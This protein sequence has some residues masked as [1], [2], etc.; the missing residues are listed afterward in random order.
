MSNR[1][2]NPTLLGNLKTK[3]WNLS[4]PGFWGTAIFLSVV[5]L[6]VKEYLTHPDFLSTGQKEQVASQKSTDSSLSVEDRA[7]AADI[8]NLP[9][10]FYNIED[11]EITSTASTPKKNTR[12]NDNKGVVNDLINANSNPGLKLANPASIPNLENPFVVQA[13]NLLQ[14]KAF[15]SDRQFSGVN[16]VT[17]LPTQIGSGEISSSSQ[18]TAPVSA[19]QTALNQ[20][21]NQN[22]PTGH[23]TSLTQMNS[24]ERSLSNPGLT[25]QPSHPM[26]N[27][28]NYNTVTATSQPQNSVP[29]PNHNLDSRFTNTQNQF[30]NT[31]VN[32][33]S[34]QSSSDITPYNLQTPNRDFVAP[35]NMM[36]SNFDSGF[37]HQ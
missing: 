20:S 30:P 17:A 7:I 14:L 21:A 34:S 6:V 1:R 29:I 18:S 4:Q 37:P 3:L 9:V 19:L 22:L 33:N 28:N 15:Q 32:L 26:M 11:A 36:K 2:F 13:E 31:S 10:L 24:F 8:D 5:G 27:G 23:G 25:R 35:S 16:G 12:T